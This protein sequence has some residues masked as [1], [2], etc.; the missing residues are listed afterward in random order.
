MDSSTRLARMALAHWTL[1]ECQIFS[2]S[3]P[4]MSSRLALLSLDQRRRLA[5]SNF[6]VSKPT[7]G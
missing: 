5:S 3:M 7:R 6:P 2:A 1:L 4:H